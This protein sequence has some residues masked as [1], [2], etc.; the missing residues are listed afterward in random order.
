MTTGTKNL[1]MRQTENQY[2]AIDLARFI[3]ALLVVVI[4]TSPLESVSAVAHFIVENIVARV[5]VPL[6]FAI[7]GF[8]FFGKQDYSGGKI[9]GDRDNLR[10][11]LS[12]CKRNTALYLGWAAVY[13]AV[14]YLPMWYRSGW[15]GLHAVKDAMAALLFSGIH[16][17]LWYLLATIYAVPFL[18][19]LLYLFPLKKVCRMAALLWI[20][21]CL[22]YS[23]AWLGTDRLP[24]V[25]FLLSRMPVVFDAAFRA[26]PL[27]TAGAVIARNPP[28][29][30]RKKT[31]FL[32]AAAFLFCAAE[33]T[34]LHVFSPNE[35]QY[36]YVF[37]TPLLAFSW[38]FCIL[39]VK[40]SRIPEIGAR[41]LR[42]M[43]LTI[44]CIH[45]LIIEA[46]D[47]CG[48]SGGWRKWLA[49]TVISVAISAAYVWF[50]IGFRE[51]RR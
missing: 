16:Y 17:H 18:Y 50:R 41:V 36:S 35:N 30:S 49:V 19:L 51:N 24:V 20:G 46:A 39:R 9:S 8:L 1:S 38:L 40:S 31:Y 13:L 45:P 42:N 3:C 15:W 21:E 2:T 23:Y 28:D 34:A 27:L 14:V 7:S 6:F 37:S 29:W 26:V 10:R 44:Y 47:A 4:H 32:C 5:A 33:A 12:F 11:L 43:S 22:T 48:I 25:A